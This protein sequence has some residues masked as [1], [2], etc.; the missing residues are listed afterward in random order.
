MHVII[1]LIKRP[2]YSSAG[3]NHMLDWYDQ[4]F[5]LGNYVLEFLDETGSCANF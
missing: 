5:L 2:F 1:L 3:Y 4:M